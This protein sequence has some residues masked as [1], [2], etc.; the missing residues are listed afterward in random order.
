MLALF[1]ANSLVSSQ[2]MIKE[3]CD[4]LIERSIVAGMA[5]LEFILS[6]VLVQMIPILLQMILLL[7]CISFQMSNEGSLMLLAF[8]L[9]SQAFNGMFWG[10]FVGS[11]S[12]DSYIGTIIVMGL[13]VLLLPISGIIWPLETLSS[14]ITQYI[15][16]CSPITLPLV[17][18]RSV[19]MRGWGCNHFHVYIGLI[20]LFVWD[21]I[22]FIL[23]FILWKIKF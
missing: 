16:S 9:F 7:V 15:S 11:V 8:I 4:G 6:Q 2:L 21:F 17:S 5:P 18:F 22:L 12:K 19:M 13:L 1:L 20:V 14:D 3:N 10:I 23:S